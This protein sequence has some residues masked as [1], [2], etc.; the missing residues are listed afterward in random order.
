MSNRRLARLAAPAAD[1]AS[2]GGRLAVLGTTAMLLAVLA[3]AAL[4]ADP[5]PKTIIKTPGAPSDV[6]AGFGSV[7]VGTHRADLLYRIDPDTNKATAISVPDSSCAPPT[8]TPTAIWF[9]GCSSNYEIDPKTDRVVARAPCCLTIYGA[10]SLWKM[11]ASTCQLVR[12]DPRTSVR[13]AEITTGISNSESQTDDG[14]A[15]IAVAYGSV[16]VYSDNAV[17]RIDTRTNER[18]HVVPLPNAKPGGNFAG[19]YLFGGLGTAAGGNI[20]VTNGAGVYRI[21]PRTNTATLLSIKLK[22]FRDGDEPEIASGA[23]SVWFHVND[24]TI[25]RVDD[26]TGK[27]I[28]TYPGDGGGGLT[29]ADG[30][31]WLAEFARDTTWREHIK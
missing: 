14:C 29:Y 30:S 13:L 10:E 11:R 22:P 18:T 12:L 15:P 20:W 27:L 8:V 17:S 6:A 24:H 4:A 1:R 5:Q 28:R 2:I 7:W 16:W 26:T 21:D 23:D 25:A 3:A 19:G 31:L 9:N